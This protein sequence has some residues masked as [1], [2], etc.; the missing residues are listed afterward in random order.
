MSNVHRN[1]L[2]RRF[3]AFLDDRFYCDGKDYWGSRLDDLI[4]EYKRIMALPEFRD[5]PQ[6][7]TNKAAEWYVMMQAIYNI[8]CSEDIRGSEYIHNNVTKEV[9]K[10][11]NVF[12]ESLLD[13]KESFRFG[14]ISYLVLVIL[15]VLLVHKCV[16]SW[17]TAL[18]V[19]L[20][21]VVCC[22]VFFLYANRRR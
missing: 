8:K 22:Y 15:S 10:S 12:L 16:I 1:S 13:F 21:M 4:P 7:K 11:G 6:F 17:V 19:H 9:R 18:L 20:F 3:I 2:R 14:W 5:D